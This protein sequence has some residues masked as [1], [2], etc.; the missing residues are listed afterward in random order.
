MNDGKFVLTEREQKIID[1]VDALEGAEH[2]KA[3]QEA[4]TQTKKEAGL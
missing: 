2:L 4:Q 1:L 3:E